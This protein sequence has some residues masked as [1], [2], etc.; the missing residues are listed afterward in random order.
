MRELTVYYDA[1]C[2]LCRDA[3]VWLEREPAYVRLRFEPAEAPAKDIV[4]MDDAGGIYRGPKAWVMCLWATRKYRG[5]SLTLATP[6]VW[7]LAK[8][9]VAWVS[10]NRAHLQP[11]G[12]ILRSMS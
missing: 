4:V 7:P 2:A 6:E 10:A 12:R 8:R 11:V 9:L 3:R 1:T 5:W